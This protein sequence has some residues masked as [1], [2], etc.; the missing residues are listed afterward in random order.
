MKR[1]NLILFLLFFICSVAL[2][3][4]KKI[5]IVTGGKNVDAGTFYP[6]FEKF[7]YDTISKPA[8]FDLFDRDKMSEY[9]VVVFYD[10]Y[11]P[12]DETQKKSFQNI[13]ES[14]IGVLFLHHSI[15]SHQ[16]WD[17]YEKIVGGRYFH[18]AYEDGGKKYGAST[19]KHD[20]DF[21]VKI[22][23]KNHPVTKDMEDFEIHDETYLNYRVQK[24]VIPLLKTDYRESGEI[25]G[26]IHT[27]KKSKVVYFMP[28]HDKQAY[29]NKGFKTLILN[30]LAFLM[31]L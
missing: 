9:G 17:E 22:I 21:L 24:Y 3:Q 23:D 15:V 14:G 28:G 30:S 5:L 4:N 16:E 1:L 26:W 6:L 12:I 27:Y 20:Q 29:G 11:Q 18:K 7:D 19:Y 8:A 10:S 2:P 13:F 25:I 31:T